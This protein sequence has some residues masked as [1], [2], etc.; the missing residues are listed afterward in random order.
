MISRYSVWLNDVSLSEID[1]RI[2]VSDIAYQAASPARNTSRLAARDGQYSGEYEYIGESKITVSF[3]ARAYETNAR[4]QIIQEVAAW[5]ADGGWLKTSDRMGQRIYV[6]CSKL[7]A[8]ASVMRWTD[9]ITVEFTAYDYPYWTDETATTL[10]LTSTGTESTGTLTIGGVH[11]SLVEATIAINGATS[12][13]EL[14]CGDTAIV[15]EG[16]SLVS[17]NTVKVVYENVHH[18]LRIYWQSQDA[19]Y[20]RRANSLLDK[21]TAASNDDLIAKVGANTLKFKATGNAVCTFS[22]RG[23]YV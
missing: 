21:R 1:P 18:I 23:V 16:L 17:T 8:V 20:Y 14:T 4:Q 19:A 11:D 7:P 22:C 13:L 9:A 12:K 6:K 15:L 3:A 10:R 5:A 2:Y